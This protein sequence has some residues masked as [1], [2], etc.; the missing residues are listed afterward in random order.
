MNLK[1]RR[2]RYILIFGMLFTGLLTACGR[3]SGSTSS[4]AEAYP[5]EG[6][7]ES[8]AAGTADMAA[9]EA[10]Y[11]EDIEYEYEDNGI[12]MQ[13]GVLTDDP[14]SNE[15]I[16]ATAS[17]R[18]LI[19]TVSLNVETEDFDTLVANVLNRITS[20]GGYTESSSVSGN[21]YGSSSSRYAY[22]TA[23]IPAAKQDQLVNEVAENSNVLSRDESV[24]DVTLNYVD[25]EAK[26]KSL[27]TEYDRLNTLI[28]SAEDL[29]TLILLEERLAEV[30]YELESY[31][32]RLRTMD[33]Q[34]EYAT[35]NI[36]IQEVVKYTPTPTHEKT[37]FERMGESFRDSCAGLLELLQDLLVFLVGIIPFLAILI[38]FAIII[39]VIIKLCTRGN[40]QGKKKKNERNV[41]SGIRVDRGTPERRQVDT[42]EPADRTENSDHVE[43]A[44]DDKK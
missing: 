30:R 22:I 10:Y 27:Q 2:L 9:E 13:K 38:V 23:R 24:D 40:R 41:Q 14:G 21:N 39:I 35:V 44:A 11:D 1:M 36:S 6:S 31:E 25:M 43:Q 42:N 32:S 33:N 34:V 20:L 8:R 28:E 37:L 16:E 3:S 19:K 12:A 18:K 26:K 15:E 17:S 7:F 29:E 4:A 5:M